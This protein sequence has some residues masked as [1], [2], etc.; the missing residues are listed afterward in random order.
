M[1][2]NKEIT[3]SQLILR[4]LICMMLD[5]ATRLVIYFWASTAGNASADSWTQ[6][7]RKLYGA[8]KSHHLELLGI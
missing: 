7:F 8:G 3:V 4:L 2:K 1:G 5:Y 6:G